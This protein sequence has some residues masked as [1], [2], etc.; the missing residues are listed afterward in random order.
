MF[1]SLKVLRLNTNKLKE[2]DRKCFCLL[3]SIEVLQLY[4]NDLTALSCFI[5]WTDLEDWKY[6]RNKLKEN[7]F[8]SN[9]DEFLEQ[10]SFN[11]T[12]LNTKLLF[13]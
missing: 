10:F 13:E 3:K 2:L 5:P 7:G 1:T 12:F 11:S 4:E 9:W 6:N 8:V